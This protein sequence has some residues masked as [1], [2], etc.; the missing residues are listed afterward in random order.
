[1]QFFLRPLIGPQITWSVPGLSLVNPSSAAL[2]VVSDRLTWSPHR[3]KH[4]EEEGAIF[5]SLVCQYG[6]VRTQESVTVFVDCLR[7][8]LGTAS[9]CICGLPQAFFGPQY[10]E[11]S[12]MKDNIKHCLT[13]QLVLTSLWNA[14]PQA[15]FLPSRNQ[16]KIFSGTRS[17]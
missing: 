3:A 16:K 15:L 13:L 14:L 12:S 9:G 4:V 1:M 5:C 2:I 6:L 11:V 7:L 17:S 10:E 8:F